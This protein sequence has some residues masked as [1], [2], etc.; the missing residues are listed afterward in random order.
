[1]IME[2]DYK[3]CRKC[4]NNFSCRLIEGCGD[5]CQN[6]IEDGPPFCKCVAGNFDN[7]GTCPYFKEKE[8]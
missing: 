3:R 4:I 8:E 2:Q 5:E 7:E 6:F 1:M